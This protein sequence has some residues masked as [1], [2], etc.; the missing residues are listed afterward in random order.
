MTIEKIKKMLNAYISE[1]LFAGKLPSDFNE[2]TPL[3]SSRIVN[4]ISVLHMVNH[5]EETLNIELEAHEVNVDNLDTV[6]L[7]S[8]FLM[9]KLNAA[10]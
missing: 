8:E 6:E 4:S 3:V 2:N 5:F 10:K 9:K 7:F 1:H